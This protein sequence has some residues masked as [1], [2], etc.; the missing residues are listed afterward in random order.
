MKSKLL[1]LTVFGPI[2]PGTVFKTL[3][4]CGKKNCKC[5]NNPEER[6]IVYRWSGYINGKNSTRTLREGTYEE[7]LKETENYKLLQQE[8]K[9]LYSEAIS[10]AP[11]N[12]K[13]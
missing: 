12:K 7:C 2:L 1:D 5:Y 3:T 6:H 8:L 4:K 13:L 11:W 9:K 10:N